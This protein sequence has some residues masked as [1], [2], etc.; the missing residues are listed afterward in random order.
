MSDYPTYPETLIPAK[1][2][3]LVAELSAVEELFA[4]RLGVTMNCGDIRL[5]KTNEAY[6]IQEKHYAKSGT[7]D[8]RFSAKFTDIAS[9]VV[10]FR[11]LVVGGAP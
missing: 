3:N 10:E 2:A 11:R 6:V 4:M 5:V 9:A 7:E 1:Y 8:W